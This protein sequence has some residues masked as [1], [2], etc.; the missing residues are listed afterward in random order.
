M[1]VFEKWRYTGSGIERALPDYVHMMLREMRDTQV[2]DDLAAATVE[3]IAT[4]LALKAQIAGL[5]AEA[6]E[7]KQAACEMLG[8]DTAEVGKTWEFP[9]IGTV[10]KTKGRRS[11][12]LNRA[13]LAKAGVSAEVL[14]ACTEVSEGEPVIRISA[15][16]AK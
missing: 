3:P 16:A 13:K 2:R 8:A 9:G 1:S 6:A 11:E 12:K 15:E 5:E 14:D 7:A 10:V 4:Y